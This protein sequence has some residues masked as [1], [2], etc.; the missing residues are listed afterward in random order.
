MKLPV[1]IHNP[2][3]LP[4]LLPSILKVCV[5]RSWKAIYPPESHSYYNTSVLLNV[6]MELNGGEWSGSSGGWWLWHTSRI[7]ATY[8]CIQSQPKPEPTYRHTSVHYSIRRVNLLDWD[9]IIIR[10][11][12]TVSIYIYVY[13]MFDYTHVF[14]SCVYVYFFRLVGMEQCINIDIESETSV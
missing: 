8:T 1:Y 11:L 9:N 10:A 12:P 13:T 6:C 7:C 5:S 14:L 3:T 4:H 2:H